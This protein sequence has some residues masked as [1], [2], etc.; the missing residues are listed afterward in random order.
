MRQGPEVRLFGQPVVLDAAG[1]IIQKLGAGKPFALLAYLLIE[2]TTSREK[3]IELLW[4]DMPESKARN[5]FRQALHRLRAALGEDTIPHNPDMLSVAGAAGIITD[6]AEFERSLDAGDPVGALEHYHGD[7]LAGLDVGESAFERWQEGK[8]KRLKARYRDAV[9]AA[10]QMDLERGE[11]LRAVDRAAGLSQ[12]DVLNA[13]SALLYATTL[14]S[15]GRRAE[16]LESLDQFEER[17]RGDLGAAAP[18]SVHEMAA[19]LRL[20][21]ADPIMRSNGRLPAS[22]VGRDG[23]LA[24]LLAHFSGVESGQGSLILI[25]APAGMGKTRLITEFFARAKDL[26]SPLL[27]LG[28]ERA[29]GSFVPFASIAEALRE[30]LDAPG[31]AGTGQ[32]LL[33]EAARLLPQ[34]RDQFSLPPTADVTDEASRLRFFEGVAALLD[35]VAYEQPVCL[36]LDDFQN[37]PDTTFDLACYLIDRLRNAPI[38]FL[39]AIRPEAAL[40]RRRRRLLDL[41]NRSGGSHPGERLETRVLTL[42]PLDSIAART[43]ARESAGVAVDDETVN[44]IVDAAQGVPY[45]ISEISQR[46]MA[47]GAIGDSPVLLREVLW[48]RLQRCTQ[49]E[50]R[51]F[52]ASALLDR[53]ASIRLLASASH[54]SERKAL[55]AALA[56]EREG[57]LIQRADGVVPAHDF[58]G[59]LALDG[60]GPA[61]RALLAGWA[62]EAIEHDRSG[63]AAEL[64]NLFAIAGRRDKT[65][66]YSRSAGYEAVA[67]GEFGI[68][69]RRFKV[70]MA[71]SASDAERSEI[72]PILRSLEGGHPQL[73][74]PEGDHAAADSG[75]EPGASP[76]EQTSSA[77]ATEGEPEKS[78]PTEEM[79]RSGVDLPTGW[80]FTRVRFAVAVGLV[81]VSIVAARTL[82]SNRA[83]IVPG[84]SLSDTLIVAEELDQRDTVIAFTTGGLGTPLREMPRASIHGPVRTWIDSL[85]VPWINPL[86]S[87]NGRYVAVE[88]VTKQGSRLYVIS[89]D[90]RDTVAITREKGDDLASGWSPDSRYLLA[91]HGETRADG[92]YNTDLYAYSVPDRGKRIPLDTAGARDVVEALWSPDGTRVA[93]TAR[94]GPQH[95]QDVFVSDADGTNLANVSDDPGEDYSIAWAPDGQT[96]VFTSERT[97]RAELFSDEITT[98]RIRRLTWDGAHADHAVFSPDGRWLAYESSKGGNPAVYVM[99]GGGG[100]GR[101]VAPQASRVSLVGWRGHTVPYV[102]RVRIEMPTFK[103]IGDSGEIAVRAFDASGDSLAVNH[104]AIRSL[105]STVI[106]TIGS[107]RVGDRDS[108]TASIK[109]IAVSSGLAR[110]TAS[111]GGWRADTAFIPIGGGQLTLL[112]E[113]FEHGIA[114]GIWRALGDPLPAVAGN[115]GSAGSA[116]VSTR[117]DRE[118]ESGILSERVFPVTPGLTADVWVKAPFGEPP[119]SGKT[120]VIALVAADPVEVP[121]SLA[122]QFLHLAAFSWS[123]VAGR[124]SYS[125]G[126]EIFSEPVARLGA[127]NHHVVRI[128]IESDG[129]VSFLVDGLE[130]WRS[131]LRVRTSGDNSRAQLWLAGQSDGNDVIFD[132]VRIALDLNARRSIRSGDSARR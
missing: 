5:A 49:T 101:S 120:F 23:E 69:A 39:L 109:A 106:R 116:G 72:A 24:A 60:T 63:N 87:P 43:I 104:L 22:F 99:P 124:L 42:P 7:F 3:A 79:N 53:P 73:S 94:I 80:G 85:R 105:D 107:V 56:L 17:Y 13:D 47:G 66:Q 121:D 57:L 98:H 103:A 86:R 15:A 59:E 2:G 55:D 90:R 77:A 110:V 117:S 28:R 51:L 83:S 30:A 127:S 128:S 62:G 75:E 52:V 113:N 48:A 44:R 122:P 123:S 36:A 45:R 81:I 32:H 84:T 119:T 82:A 102:D 92:R 112:S 132:D 58:A 71:S 25:E 64:A 19:R 40:E 74:A 114:R 20:A 96:L 70:A 18:R 65:F 16:A 89:D 68:A 125:V 129:R 10:V 8:R 54:L 78:R 91:T 14:V 9:Q 118:W 126:R 27:L 67:A 130:R 12:S 41:A 1:N 31:I 95:Q 108:R 93:W 26:S 35:S 6:V 61:G 37:C 34:L 100:S 131:T 29:E 46:A 88:R 76:A 115:A 21:P 4:G 11:L 50:Q 38:L 111:A 97:G 33:A